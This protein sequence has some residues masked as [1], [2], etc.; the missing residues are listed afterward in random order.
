VGPNRGSFTPDGRHA[1]WGGSDFVIR[2]FRMTS[3]DQADRPA[4][5][6]KPDLGNAAASR[7][8]QDCVINTTLIGGNRR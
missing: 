5:A 3:T 4:S 6:A 7:T 2:M 1:L 8:D